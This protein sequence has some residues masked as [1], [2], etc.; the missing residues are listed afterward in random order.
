MAYEGLTAEEYRD[1]LE[2]RGASEED[3]QAAVNELESR[4]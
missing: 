1:W 4:R 2:Q 3:I